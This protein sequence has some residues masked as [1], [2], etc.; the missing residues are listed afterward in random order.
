VR[1]RRSVRRYRHTFS[2]EDLDDAVGLRSFA[3]SSEGSVMMDDAQSFCAWLRGV[4]RPWDIGQ[5]IRD[6]TIPSEPFE[7]TF[8]VTWPNEEG[9]FLVPQEL[10]D[11]PWF[12]ILSRLEDNPR[13]ES[14]RRHHRQY[15]PARAGRRWP[16][17]PWLKGRLRHWRS[18][19]R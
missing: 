11:D 17:R 8:E 12:G 5:L 14:A 16:Q 4:I 6:G 2:A 13:R 15:W 19:S 9:G 7:G 1:Y 18:E 10:V 3:D